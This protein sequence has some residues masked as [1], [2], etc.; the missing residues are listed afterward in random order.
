MHVKYLQILNRKL[1]RAFLQLNENVNIF[2]GDNAQGKTNIL[3]K[4]ILLQLSVHRTNKEKKL[5]VGSESG[6]Y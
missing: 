3:E 4:H 1:Q 5:F 6:L 2:V